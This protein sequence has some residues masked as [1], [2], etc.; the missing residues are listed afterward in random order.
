M[1]YSGIF[2]LNPTEHIIAYRTERK[3][4]KRTIEL[5]KFNFTSVRKHKQSEYWMK[6][7]I[8]L[9]HVTLLS[10][11]TVPIIFDH[12]FESFLYLFI[13]VDNNIKRVRKLK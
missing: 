5:L 8:T 13:G 2:L 3:L 7:D 9:T 11:I 12:V 1:R 4:R 10:A 6:S